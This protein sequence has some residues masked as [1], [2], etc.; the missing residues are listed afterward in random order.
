MFSKL[1][2]T[3]KNEQISRHSE[4][5]HTISIPV[6]NEALQ[7]ITKSACYRS[8]GKENPWSRKPT[9]QLPPFINVMRGTS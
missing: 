7:L 8:A 4:G 9:R 5:I 1:F 2:G 3:G 6:R